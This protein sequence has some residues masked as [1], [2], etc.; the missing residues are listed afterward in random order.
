MLKQY[1]HDT[2]YVVSDEGFIVGPKGI[3]LK[4]YITDKGYRTVCVRD[5][6]G[7]RRYIKEHRIILET[8]NGPCPPGMEGCHGNGV[9][10]DNRLENLRWDTPV[11][12]AADRIKSRRSECVNGH[13]YTKENTYYRPGVGKTGAKYRECRKCKN[14]G[15]KAQP[16]GNRGAL[17]PESC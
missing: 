6:N 17:V 1:P 2:R 5:A 8:F 9:R 3:K 10:S 15:T 13:P 11:S 16:Q 4:G 12:N 7:K 14:S